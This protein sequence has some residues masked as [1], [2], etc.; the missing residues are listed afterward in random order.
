MA[1]VLLGGLTRSLAHAARLARTARLLADDGHT[2]L[3]AGEPDWLAHPALRAPGPLHPLAEPPLAAV[4]APAMGQAS[5]R[6]EPARF[7]AALAGDLALIDALHPDLVI[8]DNRRSLL[9]AA[10]AR[11]LPSIAFTTANLLGPHFGVWPSWALVEGVLGPAMGLPIGSALRPPG[12]RDTD[13]VPLQAPPLSDAFAAVFAAHGLRPPDTVIA[14]G[15]GARTLLFDPPAL[16]PVLRPPPGVRVVG[17][18]LPALDAPVVPPPAGPGPLAVLSFGS[19]G[20]PSLLP[21]ARDALL[22]AGFRVLVSAAPPA[23]P[24]VAGAP[25]LDMDAALAAADLFV[26]HGGTLS[27][28]HALAHGVPVLSVPAHVEQALTAVAL[29]ENHLGLHLAAAAVRAEPPLLGDAARAAL[30]DPA[31]RARARAAA[32]TIDPGAAPAA[33]R[34]TLAELLGAPP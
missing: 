9:A 31:L 27:V 3:L 34:A 18:L 7:A 26:C 32:T 14:L 15:L 25:L 13:R 22:D 17:P 2:P 12:A 29:L 24:R 21:L 5:L 1:R 33:I 11:G 20:D 16:I 4:L 23:H 30:A 6:A 19:T 10:A 8:A 28:Y